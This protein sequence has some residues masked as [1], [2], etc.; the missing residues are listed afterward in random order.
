MVVVLGV[1]AE[2]CVLRVA[3]YRDQDNGDW[4]IQSGFFFCFFIFVAL[5]DTS[6][7]IPNRFSR[8]TP[9]MF[10]SEEDDDD[11]FHAGVLVAVGAVVLVGGS[12]FMFLVCKLELNYLEAFADETRFKVHTSETF[13]I[14]VVQSG[15]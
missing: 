8:Q 10:A 11:D 3:V 5:V 14:L 9:K 7:S 6:Y 12:T 13:A 15:N 2:V 4:N 1:A